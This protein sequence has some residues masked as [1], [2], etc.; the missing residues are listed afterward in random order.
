[1]SGRAVARPIA[2]R[3]WRY[4]RWLLLA[5]HPDD[6]TLGT[7][8][9]IAQLGATDCLAG[10]VYLTDG[11][12]SHPVR[13]DRAGR[14]I[15]TRKREGT[16][17]LRRLL[18]GRG[19]APL[20]LGWR[21]AHPEDVDSPAFARSRRRLAALCVRLRV[22]IIATTALQ[23]PHCDHAAAARLACAVKSSCK[24]RLFVAEYPVWGAPPTARTH[25]ALMTRPMLPGVRRH[26]LAAHRSQLTA[27]HGEGFRLP[28]DKRRMTPH[29]ILY[30][31]RR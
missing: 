27:A 14:L 19:S 28:K 8:A 29:D 21:D 26:A 22:D 17:A 9:L 23:E 1:M 25:R 20:F 3:P 5:P 24:R 15:A 16:L 6:E 31:R 12:G 11:S 18:G 10:L 2:G 7:G 4:R 13:D 30:V